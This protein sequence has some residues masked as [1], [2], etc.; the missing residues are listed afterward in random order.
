MKRSIYICFDAN[1]IISNFSGKNNIFVEK[2]IDKIDEGKVTVLLPEQLVLEVERRFINNAADIV[3]VELAF[4]ENQKKI[5]FQFISQNKKTQKETTVMVKKILELIDNRIVKCYKDLERKVWD[6]NNAEEYSSIKNF[7]NKAVV[8]NENDQIYS[9]VDKKIKKGNPPYWCKDSD[10]EKKESEKRG[11]AI[12]WETLLLYF[13]EQKIKKQLYFVSKDGHFRKMPFLL[14]EWGEKTGGK[15]KF[16]EEIQDLVA[17]SSKEKNSMEKQ[18][19]EGSLKYFTTTASN[20]IN[21]VYNGFGASSFADGMLSAS[22]TIITLPPGRTV[23]DSNAWLSQEQSGLSLPCLDGAM[24]YSDT[25]L[26]EYKNSI[27]KDGNKASCNYIGQDGKKNKK[28]DTQD[29]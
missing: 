17:L 22:P 9:E 18:V 23:I 25:Q 16:V 11:D 28:S 1:A 13:K 8:I 29:I 20:Y 7:L 6:L 3:K 14:K 24:L 21:S 26:K 27:L 4:L 10:I 5:F 15:L 19:E 2:L 12:I